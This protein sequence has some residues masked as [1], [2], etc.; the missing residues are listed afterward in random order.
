MA[1]LD[2]WALA[3][4]VA[5]SSALASPIAAQ[6]L[7][8]GAPFSSG[9]VLQRGQPIPVWGTGEPGTQIAV[10]L[11]EETQSASVAPDGSWQ[12]E[13]APKTDT[14]E[15]TLT[16]R[17]KGTQALVSDIAIGDVILCSGQSNMVWKMSQSALKAEDRLQPVDEQIRLLTVPLVTSPVE[18]ARFGEGAGWSKAADTWA[19]F[20]AIC[21][22]AGREIAKAEGVTVGLINSS[23][24]GTQIRSWLPYESL[25]SVGGMDDQLAILDDYH[26]DPIAA[27]AT[28]GAMLDD[29]WLQR[30]SPNRTRRGREGYAN[31]FNGMIAPLGPTRFAGAIWYQGESDAGHGDSTQTYQQFLEA[32]IAGWRGRLGDDLPFVIVQLAGYGALSGA[33]DNDRWAAVREAQRL[34]ARDDPMSELVVT[35]DVGERLDIHPPI[36]RPVGE[37][38]GAALLKLG[39]GRSDAYNPPAALSAQNLGTW[40]EVAVSPGKGALFAASWGRPG[41]FILCED[42]AGENC[43]FADAAFSEAGVSIAIPSGMN[44]VLVR[45][46]WDAAPLCNVFD[47]SEMPLGPFEL[48]I[49]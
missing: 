13:F 19:D 23:W 38:A 18:L 49:E 24:G 41:P 9:M 28:H 22:F 8:F 36:K 4:I 27:A 11:S 26:R 20:S 17:G 30:P 34:V 1:R 7:S 14:A 42:A 10:T 2:R 3:A 29:L 43:R 33:A 44:P 21:L 31:L 15:A 6:E 46:C 40:V 45:Y 47:Q 16:A 48:A 12:V 37:R 35:I 32:M 5:A 39:F 25:A